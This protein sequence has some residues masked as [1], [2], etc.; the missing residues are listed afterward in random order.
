MLFLQ[1]L[2]WPLTIDGRR[3]RRLKP[4]AIAWPHC[5]LGAL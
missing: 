5:W 4:L 2:E 3:S 1:G